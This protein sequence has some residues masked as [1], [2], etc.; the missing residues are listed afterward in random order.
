MT[1]EEVLKLIAENETLVGLDLSG[2]D[3][4]GADLTGDDLRTVFSASRI[5][6]GPT[7]T[8]S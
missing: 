5:F 7:C 4:T 6:T 2:I 1:K 3:L 8:A